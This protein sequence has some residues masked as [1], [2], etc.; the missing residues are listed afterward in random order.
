[1]KNNI[2]TQQVSFWKFLRE[3]QIEI[4][5]I[6]RDYAQG[7]LGKEY[8]RKAFL[9][10]LKFALDSR[11]TLKLDFVYGVTD[12][13]RFNPLDGQQRLTTL[14]L[15]HWYIAYRANKIDDEAKKVFRHFTYETRLSSRE[16]CDRL[17]GL[18]NQEQTE[19]NIA[20]YIKKQTW[21][22][23][24]WKQ[25]PTIQSMLRMLSGT[26]RS[27]KKGNDILDGIQELFAGCTFEQFVD[28]WQLLINEKCPIVFYNLDL[29]GLNLSDDLY[30]KMNARGERLTNFENFKSDLIG[31]IVE[32]AREENA[33]DG[34]TSLLD[35]KTGIAIKLDTTWTDIFWRYNQE[36][37]IDDIYFAFLNRFFFKV[38]ILDG[39]KDFLG[40]K[41]NESFNV[42]Y[43]KESNDTTLCY[44][45]F[46]IYKYVNGNL[47]LKTLQTLMKT[48]NNLSAYIENGNI[49]NINEEFRALWVKKF[50]FIPKYDN[51]SGITWNVTIRRAVIY[52]I[53]RFFECNDNVNDEQ[54]RINLKRWLRVVWNIVSNDTANLTGC[55]QL[56]K[57]LSE[58]TTDIYE[59]LA[60]DSNEIQSKADKA[61]VEEEREKARQILTGTI[62]NTETER[63]NI[64]IE[65]E[66]FGFFQGAIRF[67]FQNEEGKADWSNFVVK[68]KN[69]KKYFDEDGIK[70]E[71]QAQWIRNY[72]KRCRSYNQ[73]YDKQIFIPN[74]STWKNILLNEINRVTIHDCL[75][76]FK[77]Y[78]D[79]S[80]FSDGNLPAE[81]T[82][83]KLL[84]DEQLVKYLL[85][86]SD[87][88]KFRIRWCYGYI[89]L[90]A[91]YGRKHITL[92][93]VYQGN[94][95]ANNRTY[96]L[97]K[98]KEYLL[99]DDNK[100]IELSDG[101]FLI[102]D[103]DIQF[104]Y[105]GHKWQWNTDGNIYLLDGSDRSKFVREGDFVI[106]D[107]VDLKKL[108]DLIF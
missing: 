104:V 40:K 92:D 61:Q 10:N 12:R 101:F 38:I 65:A 14:W 51:E 70:K 76:S 3:N 11:E 45:S 55:L 90:Y 36:G 68:F 27:D 93:W 32:K 5:I 89:T 71:Y 62:G 44:Q 60:N 78:T 7:R 22:F 26:T 30:I 28:Y 108:G 96:Y 91:P 87:Y 100:K 99:V 4:P 80:Q 16:F 48:L 103:F 107:E 35:P 52:A 34:W 84:C 37:K 105:K 13:N 83:R 47:P 46:S 73:L 64:I 77:P 33:E 82:V 42:L 67:L 57:E 41:D 75:I 63:E 59:F 58:H 94:S 43:G 6:Q 69:A 23:S 15:L 1:M 20:D 95:V 17:V 56:I 66:S 19:E 24:D 102:W 31:Y 25:D 85:S 53:C 18:K 79:V 86:N 49:V 50:C 54:F 74:A 39:N 29:L 8:L 9:E 72:I 106:K 81:E 21:F 98:M 88:Q 2:A 97:N